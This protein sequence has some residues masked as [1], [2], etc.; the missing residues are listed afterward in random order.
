MILESF[1]V[2]S[3]KVYYADQIIYYRTIHNIYS[4]TQQLTYNLILKNN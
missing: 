1:T 3:T 4:H 2:F